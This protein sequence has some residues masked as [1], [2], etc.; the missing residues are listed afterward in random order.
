[1]GAVTKAGT[2]EAFGFLSE[3]VL[4]LFEDLLSPDLRVGMSATRD[5][6][7]LLGDLSTEEVEVALASAA[8]VP[9]QV[10]GAMFSRELDNDDL[11]AQLEVPALIVHGSDDR[12]VRT[13]S[14]EHIAGLVPDGTLVMYEGA[15][16]LPH[17]ERAERFDT[18]LAEFVRLIHPQP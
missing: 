5:F 13:S 12:I 18:D 10:R 4:A 1:M 14:S 9:P 3:E 16:H 17:M 7:R 11:L 2:E 8:M 6:V 15:G